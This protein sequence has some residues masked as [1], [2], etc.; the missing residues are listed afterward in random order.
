MKSSN[1]ILL[2]TTAAVALVAGFANLAWAQEQPAQ[3]TPSAAPPAASSSSSSDEAIV[4]T[5]SRIKKN[6]FNSSSPLQVITSENAELKGT[7]DTAEMLQGSSLAAGSPQNDATISSAFVTEGG[8]G[9]QTL[10]LRGLGANRTLVLLNGRRA[11]PAGTRGQVSAFDLNVIPQSQ[12]DRVE[13]LKDG[14]S[15]IYGSDA[16][17]GVANIITKKVEGGEVRVFGDMPQDGGGNT[18]SA[19]AIYGKSFSRGS[20]SISADYY[21]QNELKFGDRDYLQCDEQYTFDASGVRNDVIDPRTGKPACRSLPSGQVWLYEYIGG[22]SAGPW[23]TGQL[24]NSPNGRVRIQYD[25][26]NALGTLVPSTIIPTPP[27]GQVGRWPQA[28]NGF[29]LVDYNRATQGVANYNPPQRLAASLIPEIKRTTV[30]AQGQ[31]DIS[32]SVEVYGEVLLNRRESKTNGFRQFWTYLYTE[33]LGDPFSVGWRGIAALSPTPITDHNKD[34]QRVDYMRAVGGLRGDFK[35]FGDLGSIAWDL[36]VQA[37]RSDGDYTSD[38]ILDDAVDSAQFRTGSCVGTITPISKKPCIDVNWLSGD[39][40]NGNPTAAEKAFLFGVETGN[41][42][43]DQVYAEGTLSG[44]VFRLP[45]GPVGAAVGFHIREDK[46]NDVPGAITRAGNAWGS[47]SAGIT[48]GTDKTKEAFAEFNIPIVAGAPLLE[49]LSLSLSGRYTDVDSY[50]SDTTHKIGLNWQITPEWRLRATQG[51]SFRAPA[52]FELFL[53]NQSSFI[54]QR[55]IDPCISWQTGLDNGTLPVR[56]A[57]NCQRAGIPGDY[58]GG[59]SSATVFTGGGKGLL[60][61]ETSEAKTLGLVWT[62][63]FADLNVAID[64]IE[65]EIADEVGRLGAAGVVVGCYNSETF[66]TD[67]L[68]KL[69]KRGQTTN[70]LAIDTVQDNYLNVNSQTNRGIDLTVRYDRELSFGDLRVQGQFTWQLEDTISLFAGNQIDTNGDVGDPDWVG[71]VDFRLTRGDWTYFWG[72]DFIGKASEAEDIGNSNTARTTFYKVHTE[73]TTYH[74]V[75]VRRKFDDF[76]VL[77]GVS[78]LFD[79]HPPAVT[80]INLGQFASEGGSVLASQYDYVGRRGFVQL[81]KKF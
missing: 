73:L 12:V 62:P 37:S 48:K 2:R 35:G 57:N 59:N 5:G 52:L 9:S 14:A 72:V 6:E 36:V 38:Q 42:V 53:A 13:I 55:T 61:A 7:N 44:D 33:D 4:V 31:Y 79:E 65:I 74:D 45:A 81:R 29:Y 77:V 28:P 1:S 43:Y 32:N 47:S 50:G 49:D 71:N 76:E 46:I 22:A 58:I 70:P 18:F 68:C 78:N 64:Y 66:P 21:Q 25:P 56:I 3:P 54:G 51:T 8:P 39:F 75:S 34:S 10:S 30:Y 60:K 26:T 17:A 63:G 20:F 15:S 80:T 40:L 69:F 27:P 23:A 19:E 67:P 16:V 24:L 41:T 11:G